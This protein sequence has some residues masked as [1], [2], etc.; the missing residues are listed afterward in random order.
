MQAQ[1]NLHHQEDTPFTFELTNTQSNNFKGKNED[2]LTYSEVEE[3][4]DESKPKSKVY[5][6]VKKKM[7]IKS[8]WK[9]NK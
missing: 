7:N 1:K 8:K 2:D 4:I 9:N 3:Q 6:R 5:F